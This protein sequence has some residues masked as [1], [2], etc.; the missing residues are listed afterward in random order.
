MIA[1][2]NNLS[3]IK[4][5]NEPFPHFFIDD[6]IDKAVLES[7]IRDVRKFDYLIE[8]E[9]PILKASS[10]VFRKGEPPG[11]LIGLGAGS[12]GELVDSV[13]FNALDENS[14][15]W[16]QLKNYFTSDIFFKEILS[17]FSDSTCFKKVFM[18]RF[19]FISLRPLLKSR[20]YKRSVFD[21]LFRRD[22]YLAVRFSRYTDNTGTTIHRDNSAKAIAFLLYLDTTGWKE[23]FK[24]GFSV[25]DNSEARHLCA[26]LYNRL[27]PENERKLM[28]YK[29]IEYKEN[30]LL[31]FC[32]TP[33]SWHQAPPTKLARNL[34]R[35]CFQIN[36][37]FCTEMAK[38]LTIV[39]RV[40]VFFRNIIKQIFGIHWTTK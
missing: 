6:A 34:Y 8:Q 38:D 5:D 22:F 35:D 29:Y 7:F 40:A 15:A 2:A 11:D 1:L 28:L 3:K 33:N 23:S 31:G 18:S 36:L 21:F 16:N 32:N 24:G 4:I 10:P 14:A 13:F 37:F 26:P 27:S 12:N 39:Y 25:Y 19:N 20:D 30:R 9:D 17:K